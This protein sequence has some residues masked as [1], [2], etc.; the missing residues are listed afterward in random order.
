MV[1]IL[2]CFKNFKECSFHTVEEKTN[3][4]FILMPFAEPFDEIYHKGIKDGLPTGWEC[5]RSDE[6]WDIPEAVCKICKSIQEA[7][8]II[9][10]VTGRNPNVFLELGLSFGLEKK[11][12][13]ITQNIDDLPFDVKTFNVIEYSPNNL[14]DLKEK[15]K[16]V[17]NQVKPV[18]RVLEEASIFRKNLKNAKEILS[19]QASYAE[20]TGRPTM[21]VFIGSKNNEQDWLP[22]SSENINL[23]RCAP[24]FLFREIIGRHDYYEFQPRSTNYYFRI[25]KN[26]FIISSFPC[27]EWD[28]EKGTI[29]VHELVGYVTD[30]YLFACRIMKE[31]EIKDNQRI[32]IEVLNVKG[33]MAKIHNEPFQLRWDYYFNDDSIDL[34]E[35]FN[36]NTDWNSLFG[37]L[38]RIYRVICEYAGIIDITDKTIK[39]NLREMFR[40]I[41]EL[42]TTYTSSG[43]TALTSFLNEAFEN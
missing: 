29:Y 37:V 6:K 11:F 31:K 23:L 43:I 20:K 28:N 4:A 26:G 18:P 25:Q 40:E 27:A 30:L 22:P 41:R 33:H 12:V 17:I 7:T 35:D 5:N 3:T 9:A 21:Q 15:L 1:K 34:E 38:V 8:L 39:T 42:H 13:L 16:E 10:D 24:N 2:I 19:I 36:P 32:R 14:D